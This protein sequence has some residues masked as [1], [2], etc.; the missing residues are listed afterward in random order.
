AVDVDE[1]RG[2]HATQLHESHQALA[3]G[4]HARVAVGAE[5]RD[6]LVDG[7]G[8]VVGERR[9]LHARASCGSGSG[10]LGLSKNSTGVN[11]MSDG[12]V[13]TRW[14][15]IDSPWPKRSAAVWDTP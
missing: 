2:L 11:T 15:I 6:G 4:E 13:L 10:R 3:A 14:W 9:G 8:C 7:A 1:R 12:P 5:Q